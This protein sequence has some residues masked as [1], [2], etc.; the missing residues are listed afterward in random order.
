MFSEAFPVVRQS[1]EDEPFNIITNIYNI[2]SHLATCFDRN[3]QL[4]N[5]CQYQQMELTA[6]S[7]KYTHDDLKGPKNGA[8]CDKILYMTVAVRARPSSIK[9]GSAQSA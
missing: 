6:V 1:I 2:L 3:G 4:A 9:A 7:L 5:T 8:K